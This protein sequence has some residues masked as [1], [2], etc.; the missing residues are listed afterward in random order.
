MTARNR[1]AVCMKLAAADLLEL[2]MLLA[3]RSRWP[4]ALFEGWKL[5]EGSLP[6]T[7]RAWGA[8]EV[9]LNWL[10]EHGHADFKRPQVQRHYEL[11]VPILPESPDDVV[12]R[13]MADAGNGNQQRQVVPTNPSTYRDMYQRGVN[14]GARALELL[15]DRLETIA[16]SG[17]PIPTSLLLDV[18]KLGSKFAVS[19][20][21]I[22]A[23]G[24]DMDRE[25]EAELEGFRSGSGPEPSP[26]FGDHRIHVIDGEARP[27]VDR[28]RADRR[29]FNKGAAEDGSPRLPA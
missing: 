24:I 18:A 6:A 29:E 14:V 9:G 11:H 16:A 7:M 13:G 27:V 10:A 4:A 22:V 21:Q 17:E 23:K 26:R 28:G 3:D 1:C 20:A 8:T 19:Q 25:R 5:P 2:D 15:G 12:A